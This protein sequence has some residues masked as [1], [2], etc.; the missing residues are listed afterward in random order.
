MV[1]VGARCAGAPVAA[2]L[3]RRGLRV[4]VVEQARFPRNTLSSHV[5]QADSIGFLDRLGVIESIRATGAPFLSGV[6]ARV[7][8][9]RFVADYPLRVDDLG[10]GACIRRH[11]LDPILAEAAAGA[12]AD[13][14][15]ATKVTGLVEEGGRVAGVRVTHGRSAMEL[16]ADLVIGADGRNSTVAKLCGARDYNVTQS[17]RAYYWTYFDSADLSAEPRFVFHRW[18]DRFVIAAPADNGMYMVGVS[19]EA[20]EREQFRRDLEGSFMDHVLSCE[21]VATLLGEPHRA[22]KIFG[23]V[24]FSGY[25]REAAGPG[26]VLVGDS[27]HF[28][29][30]AAGRGIGDAFR[31]VEMLAPAVTAGLGGSGGMGPALARWG[32]WRDDEFAEH[33]WAGADFGRAGPVGQIFSAAIER[34]SAEGD[35]GRFLELLS[36]RVRPSELLTPGSLLRVTGGLLRRPGQRRAVLGELRTLV[37]QQVRRHWVNRHPVFAPAAPTVADAGSA[38]HEMVGV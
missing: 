34:L 10:G 32:R 30:P 25:F 2:M 14:R 38:E 16:R 12:G 5:M 17:Q 20:T 33:Y 15:M 36:H 22:A 23:I 21:P 37:G 9:L 19:P 7:E 6:D 4:V 18:G 35:T 27:G 28:K 26:W 3:A 29:D 8:D 24:R 1:V 13:V 11:V 31:Q